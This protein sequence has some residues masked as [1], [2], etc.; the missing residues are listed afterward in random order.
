MLTKF[1]LLYLKGRPRHS[2]EVNIKID[3]NYV[4]LEGVYWTCVAV[5]RDWWRA[6]M[7]TVL[8]LLVP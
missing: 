4:V 3:I 2:W 8:K 1:W 7:K 6:V 5:N